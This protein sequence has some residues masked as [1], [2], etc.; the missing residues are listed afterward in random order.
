M[1]CEEMIYSNDYVD[2]FLNNYDENSSQIALYESSCVN[3]IMD[4]IAIFH[5]EKGSQYLTNL[6]TVPYASIPKVFG[7][8]D[9]TNMEVTGVKQVQNPSYLGLDGAGTIVGIIDTGI[10]YDNA[11]FLDA[12]GKSRIGVIWDQSIPAKGSREEQTWS[13][14]PV[15][16][17][18]YFKEEIDRALQTEN[19]YDVVPTR[20]E[21]GHGTFMAGI[22]T[23]GVDLDNDFTGIA[24]GAEIAVVKL[25]EAK[26]YL[27]E[28]FQ[29]NQDV[30]AYAESDVI[31]AVNYLVRYARQQRKPLSLL[32]GVG[33]SNGGHNG[34]TYLEIYLSRLLEN[35]GFMVSAPAGNEGAERLHY[36]G[37][38]SGD[39]ENIEVEFNV[40]EGQSGLTMEFWGNAPTTFS[41]GL[42]SPRGDRIEQIAPRFGK[43]EEIT[44]SLS[45]TFVYVAYQLAEAYSGNELIFI[46]LVNPTPGL[47]R[48]IVYAREENQKSFNIWMPLRQFLRPNTFFLQGSPNNTITVPGNAE[49]V[50]TMTA[51]NHLN[52]SIYAQASRG[53]NTRNQIKPNLT[54]PGVDITGPG[55]RNNYVRRT[56]T[57]VAAAHSA[58]MIAMF[59]QWDLENYRLGMFF[60]GQVQSF[61]QKGAG[62][63]DQTVYPNPIW[64]YGIMNIAQTFEAFRTTSYPI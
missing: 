4:K 15:Y 43:E 10:M 31:Y 34:F 51:Y 56:G 64:G 12:N 35:V 11:L 41:V 32:I 7:L 47:W 16:G 55:L 42:V 20:D 59:L 63:S 57:S 19:P 52:G 28:Y 23:G 17:S 29:I 44:L 58:G 8:M 60:A 3:E 30:P 48:L 33:S 18:V 38:W 13:L 53:Y 2:L 1:T 50:M 39:E 6:E 14:L 37:E 5:A 26:P 36:Y 27:R 46:R 54:A 9:S 45:R 24:T 62:R 25:K 21:N 40:D 61:F 49:L 22:A